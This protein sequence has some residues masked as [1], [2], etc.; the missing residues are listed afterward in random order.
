VAEDAKKPEHDK[1]IFGLTFYLDLTTWFDDLCEST[2]GTQGSISHLGHGHELPA[3]T[4]WGGK[5]VQ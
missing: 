2:Q 1:F 5:G 3:V 4:T